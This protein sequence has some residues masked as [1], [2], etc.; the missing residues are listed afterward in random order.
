MD[1][2]AEVE[3]IR[4]LEARYAPVTTHGELDDWLAAQI[5]KSYHNLHNEEPVVFRFRE[6]VILYIP[7]SELINATR[8]VGKDI[9]EHCLLVERFMY[10]NYGIRRLNYRGVGCPIQLALEDFELIGMQLANEL[11][12]WYQNISLASN[13]LDS[14]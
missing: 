2:K 13:K 5:M 12:A 3:T 10:N 9:T 14:N 8:L 4:H 1:L 6:A 7:E 11:I